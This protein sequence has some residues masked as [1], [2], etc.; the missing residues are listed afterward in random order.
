MTK[1]SASLKQQLEALKQNVYLDSDGQD[2]HPCYNFYDWFCKQSSLE[3]K[4]KSLYGN[5]RTF[6]KHTPSI[7]TEKVYV[8]FKNNCPVDGPLYDSFSI[9]DIETGDVI[10]WV[11]PRCGHSGKAEIVFIPND[12]TTSAD[13]FKGLF[14]K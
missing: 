10:Y 8:F 12:T 2:S 13:T 3:R 5:V 7:D 1:K 11:T 4:A 6:L 14:K 9:C